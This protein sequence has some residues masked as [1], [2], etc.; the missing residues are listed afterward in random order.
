MIIED[1]EVIIYNFWETLLL[2]IA[3]GVFCVSFTYVY[4]CKF[5][6]WVKQKV[7]GCDRKKDGEVDE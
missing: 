7:Y 4:W 6:P 1:A 3:I 5:L 2:Y